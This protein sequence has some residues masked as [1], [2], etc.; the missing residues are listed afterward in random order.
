MDKTDD[1]SKDVL[2][3]EENS[4]PFH[5]RINHFEGMNDT[6]VKF[7]TPTQ[8]GEL[9]SCNYRLSL[10]KA[11]NDYLMEI[12]QKEGRE[13][14]ERSEFEIET[15]QET[16]DREGMPHSDFFDINIKSETIFKELDVIKKRLDDRK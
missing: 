10:H 2:N 15:D 8:Q 1:P 7:F 11:L 9:L 5:K 4:K 6:E 16:E 12:R 3:E 14:S 13:I